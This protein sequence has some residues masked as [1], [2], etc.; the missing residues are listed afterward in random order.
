MCSSNYWLNGQICKEYIDKESA[1]DFGYFIQG[2]EGFISN[3]L[4]A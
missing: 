4:T 3:V 2:N 1:G